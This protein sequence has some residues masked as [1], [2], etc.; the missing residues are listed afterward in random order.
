MSYPDL[1]IAISTKLI[2]MFLNITLNGSLI[3]SIEVCHHFSGEKQLVMEAQAVGI[4][5]LLDDF[6][7]IVVI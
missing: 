2:P 7:G 1:K 6:K 3:H 5:V 4:Q